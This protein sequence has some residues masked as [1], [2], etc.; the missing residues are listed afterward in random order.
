MTKAL[1]GFFLI[2]GVALNPK[3]YSIFTDYIRYVRAR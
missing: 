2:I 1:F 3:R